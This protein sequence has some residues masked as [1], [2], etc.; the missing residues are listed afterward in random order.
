M[1]QES[2]NSGYFYSD[3]LSNPDLSSVFYPI[4][5]EKKEEQEN[6][7]ELNILFCRDYLNIYK[8]K[9][10]NINGIKAACNC[11][12]LEDL[13]LK[14][15]LKQVKDSKMDINNIK[16]KTHKNFFQFHCYDCVEDLCEECLIF[17]FVHKG[18]TILLYC[19]NDFS[20]KGSEKEIL[21]KVVK[22]IKENIEKYKND[23]NPLYF[24]TD[25]YFL[26]NL[27]N[28][29][30]QIKDKIEERNKNKNLI[31]I[32]LYEKFEILEESLSFLKKSYQ[33]APNFN[34]YRSLS[35]APEDLKNCDNFFEGNFN[36]YKKM[37]KIN[38][39]EEF[40][41]K[42]D[43]GES[44]KSISINKQNF[45]NLNL[46]CSINLINLFK[47]QLNVNNIDDLSPLINAKFIHIRHLSFC[48]NK[49]GNKNIK[50]LPKFN[51][52]ELLSFDLY[53]NNITDFNF[54]KENKNF[55]KLKQLMIG[56]NTFKDFDNKNNQNFIYDCSSI[57]EI[58][59]TN[60]VFTDKS[61][62]NIISYFKFD[63]LEL[64][65]CQ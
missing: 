36:D 50:Y 57:E 6:N 22:K 33:K 15:Y 18:H 54:F 28:Y 29:K 2:N 7:K 38:S 39:I 11:S 47:L 65:Y 46:L 34:S 21:E 4:E 56:A 63:S 5:S 31:R 10:K 37:I 16:C 44:I 62:I 19:D 24:L 32:D 60:G 40:N 8:I 14:E 55:P 17:N 58:G 59:L 45:N 49:I 35:K 27:E 23:N 9:F 1:L 25:K 61:I 3:K 20:E 52:K 64:L 51:F 53:G 42:K 43:K 41:L 13:S 30:K 12:C 26:Q 48:V